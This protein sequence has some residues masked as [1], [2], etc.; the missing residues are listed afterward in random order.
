MV[1]RLSFDQTQLEI[2]QRSNKPLERFV[3]R[4]E[5]VE[6][7]LRSV[8]IEWNYRDRVYFRRDHH[9]AA[10]MHFEKEMFDANIGNDNIRQRERIDKASDII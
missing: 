2:K 6:F 1:D 4:R 5:N 10:T 9:G 7:A 3:D 8:E